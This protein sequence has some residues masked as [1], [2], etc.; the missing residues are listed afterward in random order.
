M[1]MELTLPIDITMLMTR[2][3]FRRLHLAALVVYPILA[4]VASLYWQADL[5]LSLILFYLVPSVYLSILNPAAIR[6]SALFAVLFGAPS[7]AIVD[8]LAHL[9]KAWA[10]HTSS[11]LLGQKIFNFTSVEQILWGA[12]SVYFVVMFYEYFFDREISRN[13]LPSSMRWLVIGTALAAGFVFLLAAVRPE[14]LDIS[15][16]YLKSGAVLALAPVVLVLMLLPWL[17]GKFLKVAAYFA[18]FNLIY[19]LTALRLNQW[20]FPGQQFIGQVTL[21]GQTFPFE[22]LFFFILL[23]SMALLCYYEV[24]DDD[25]R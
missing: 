18:I 21:L 7:Y 6:K 20:S 15:Y 11:G 17:S 8:Y 5:W 25:R 14:K 12:F 16:F 23:G 24:F 22:E 4:S 1:S 19:E 3:N 13:S 9:T 10:L 2:F